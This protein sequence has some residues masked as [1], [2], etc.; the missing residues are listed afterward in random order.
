MIKFTIDCFDI[1]IFMI[2]F[3]SVI[4]P[5]VVIAPNKDSIGG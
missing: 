5:E 1:N 4:F 3:K 2:N